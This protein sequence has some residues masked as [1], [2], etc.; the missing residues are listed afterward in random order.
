M[1]HRSSAFPLLLSVWRL[2]A[3]SE[4]GTGLGCGLGLSALRSKTDTTR[5]GRN[6]CFSRIRGVPRV[7][8]ASSTSPQASAAACLGFILLSLE[9]GIVGRD[10]C[11]P[12]S[13]FCDGY[14][15]T[16]PILIRMFVSKFEA[17]RRLILNAFFLF[18][19]TCLRL[20][21]G[22]D[23]PFAE[24]SVQIVERARMVSHRAKDRRNQKI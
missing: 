22:P 15:V 3:G 4:L 5:I 16:I 8:A 19:A 18:L 2:A 21:G 13:S 20:I 9:P 6:I 14:D 11:R 10:T 1:R 7:A 24:S 23:L 17:Q 12:L